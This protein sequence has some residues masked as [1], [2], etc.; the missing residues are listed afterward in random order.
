MK[1][2]KKR[3]KN[4]LY[5]IFGTVNVNSPTYRKVV[6]HSDLLRKN[7][8]RIKYCFA[9]YEWMRFDGY[10]QNEKSEKCNEAE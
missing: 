4:I 9:K 1:L 7:G 6:N 8:K 10:T 3:T 2:S 5:R